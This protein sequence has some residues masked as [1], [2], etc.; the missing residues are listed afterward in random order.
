MK[1]IDIAYMD[2]DTGDNLVLD[3]YYAGMNTLLDKKRIIRFTRILSTKKFYKT[4]NHPRF[5]A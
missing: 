3:E 2:Q 5:R 4:K 1:A